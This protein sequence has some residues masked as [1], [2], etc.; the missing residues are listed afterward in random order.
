MSSTTTNNRI[1]KIAI[2]G[3]SGNLGTPL[4]TALLSSSSHTITALTRPTSTS[5]FPPSVIV[6]KVDYT[7]PSS[8]VDALTGQDLLLIILKAWTPPEVHQT[9]VRAAVDAG[10]KFILPSTWGGDVSLAS[11]PAWRDDPIQTSALYVKQVREA[12]GKWINVC[13]GF[14]YE[15]SLVLSEACFGF[16]LE[17]KRVTFYGDGERK[18]CSSSWGYVGEAVKRFVALPVSR[19]EEGEGYNGAVVEDWADETLYISEFEVSQKDMLESLCRVLGSKKEEWGIGY[20][21]IEERVK[22]GEKEMGEGN[23]LGFAK[24]LYARG[25]REG[26]MQFEE[27]ARR[28]AE[29]LGLREVDGKAQEEKVDEATR[30]GLEMVRN[31]WNPFKSG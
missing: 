15:W 13:C 21:D 5:T 18:I 22:E 12:G 30:R 27:P 4:L 7:S 29:R 14:W 1:T 10:V 26:A 28:D 23:M 6:K 17:G 2:I 25:F 16:D 24:A 8:L 20:Q 31:G 11:S 19:V 9:I 3:G